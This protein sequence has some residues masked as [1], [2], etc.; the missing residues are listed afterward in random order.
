V[1]PQVVGIALAVPLLVGLLEGDVDGI[2]ETEPPVLVH[3]PLPAP[4]AWG[5]RPADQPWI[6]SSTIATASPTLAA[7]GADA[8]AGPV[9]TSASSGRKEA[10]TIG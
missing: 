2:I 4:A 5:A 9:S 10:L 3:G 6:V 8:P 7:A 1:T